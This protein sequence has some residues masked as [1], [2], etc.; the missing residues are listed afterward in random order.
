MGLADAGAGSPCAVPVFDQAGVCERSRPRVRCRAGLDIVHLMTS[1]G[2]S[3]SPRDMALVLYKVRLVREGHRRIGRRCDVRVSSLG[4][5]LKCFPVSVSQLPWCLMGC[6]C[7]C[8]GR[9]V[10]EIILLRERA[11]AC[12]VSFLQAAGVLLSAGCRYQVSVGMSDIFHDHVTRCRP[13][14]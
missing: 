9:V 12:L 4:R 3:C 11:A 5:F 7:W 13:M 8:S 6:P 14:F 2:L 1:L 10:H